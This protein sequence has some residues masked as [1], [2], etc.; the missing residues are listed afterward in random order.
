MTLSF[1]ELVKSWE[2]PSFAGMI[3]YSAFRL[4]T[5]PSVL[6]HYFLKQKAKRLTL[7][8]VNRMHIQQ[9]LRHTRGKIHGPGGAAEFLGINPNTLRFK[10]R[11]LGIPLKTGKKDILAKPDGLVKSRHS[12]KNRSP[13]FL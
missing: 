2:T 5:R 12:G 4:F 6:V 8:E 13:V 7:D 1:D 11:K 3:E 10:M 9:T